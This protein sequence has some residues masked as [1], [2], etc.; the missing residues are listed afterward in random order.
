[1]I[2][3]VAEVDKADREAKA[4]LRRVVK[5]KLDN[6]RKNINQQQPELIRTGQR[7]YHDSSASSSSFEDLDSEEG[8]ESYRSSQGPEMNNNANGF[9]DMVIH[10]DPGT[11]FSESGKILDTNRELKPLP[12]SRV[13]AGKEDS[14][15]TEKLDFEAVHKDAFDAFFASLSSKEPSVR[16]PGMPEPFRLRTSMMRQINDVHHIFLSLDPL[17]NVEVDAV[18]YELDLELKKIFTEWCR[19]F[20][21]QPFVNSDRKVA[22][23]ILLREL[24]VNVRLEHPSVDALRMRPYYEIRLFS[25]VATKVTKIHAEK[26]ANQIGNLIL[27]ANFLETHEP[28]FEE[29]RELW[30]QQR[31]SL[32][33]APTCEDHQMHGPCVEECRE[34]RH[35]QRA[36][37]EKA[38]FS[39]CC[40]MCR[41]IRKGQQRDIVDAMSQ[42]YR[43]SIY[44]DWL[45]LVQKVYEDFDLK[46]DNAVYLSGELCRLIAKEES[47]RDQSAVTALAND[48]GS[49]SLQSIIKISMLKHMEANSTVLSTRESLALLGSRDRLLE[50]V[51]RLIKESIRFEEDC[52]KVVDYTRDWLK[53]WRDKYDEEYKLAF[54]VLRKPGKPPSKYNNGSTDFDTI[55]RKWSLAP[56]LQAMYNELIEFS[57]G[58]A[59]THDLDKILMKA[60]K[61]FSFPTDTDYQDM[62]RVV[63]SMRQKHTQPQSF[64]R[65]LSRKLAASILNEPQMQQLCSHENV[66][67]NIC[68]IMKS[69]I[70]RCISN[71][72]SD[73]KDPYA[74]VVDGS[75]FY[76][77][78]FLK[79]KDTENKV[80]Q[81]NDLNKK[82]VWN[83]S[84]EG[85]VIKTETTIDQI[86]IDEIAIV[87]DS[88]KILQKTLTEYMSNMCRE[89]TR[90]AGD[91]LTKVSEIEKHLNQFVEQP[92][93]YGES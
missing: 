44:T 36:S 3:K 18:L 17:Y 55:K 50:S 79:V 25:Y 9:H 49:G 16:V 87:F 10:L 58:L 52:A 34:L 47:F 69:K 62:E 11:D 66:K 13:P 56:E 82:H 91:S 14:S 81:E 22:L 60:L 90:I 48:Q 86:I 23:L 8:S 53:K 89:L 27:S 21:K 59:T 31:A 46:V 41:D 24:K 93:D 33:K 28:Y 73:W 78:L 75:E 7:K 35:Q 63:C 30:Q 77:F 85:K 37:L 1:L 43:T 12:I 45:M 65:N 61:N 68:G 76:R 70:V 51:T 32:E 2:T 57:R 67:M 72:E 83:V 74:R 19:P 42:E 88:T 54:K 38:L 15:A 40:Q 39:K 84:V 6:L 80:T 26:I 5:A 29:C 71:I 92:S 4:A 64:S 20:S